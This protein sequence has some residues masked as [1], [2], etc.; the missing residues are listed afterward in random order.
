MWWLFEEQRDDDSLNN[1][2]GGARDAHIGERCVEEN[3]PV[4]HQ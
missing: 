2:Q 1:N 3:K 4:F